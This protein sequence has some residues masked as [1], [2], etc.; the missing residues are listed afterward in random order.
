MYSSKLFAL[1][2]LTLPRPLSSI[3]RREVE[4]RIRYI[5]FC[6]HQDISTLFQKYFTFFTNTNLNL[7]PWGHLWTSYQPL[8]KKIYWNNV[9]KKGWKNVHRPYHEHCLV[10]ELMSEMI[11][12]AATYFG[13]VKGYLHLPFEA[14]HC[15]IWK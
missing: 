7:Y 15:Y 14:A 8:K 10:L 4:I 11:A 2:P 6:Y 5:L 13:R 9:W 3:E 1:F 12:L